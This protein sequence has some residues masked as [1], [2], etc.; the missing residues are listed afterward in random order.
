M[1]QNNIKIT[2]TVTTINT[3]ITDSATSTIMVHGIVSLLGDAVCKR[4][5]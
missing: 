3:T 2:M 1:K 4:N 5:W